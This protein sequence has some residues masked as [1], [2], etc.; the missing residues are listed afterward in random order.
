MPGTRLTQGIAALAILF[1]AMAVA[2]DGEIPLFIGISL[3]WVIA[4]RSI[5]FDR[6]CRTVTGSLGVERSLDRHLI[7]EMN[8]TR[9]ATTVTLAVPPRVAVAVREILPP[10][11]FLHQGTLDAE[12]TGTEVQVPLEIPLTYEIMAKVHG[13]LKFP[14]ISLRI[15]DRFF[16]REIL[17]TA[18]GFGG[19]EILVQPRPDFETSRRQSEF[20]TREIEKSAFITGLGIRGFREYSAGDDLRQIDWKLS[21]KHEKLLIREYMGIMRQSPLLIID[22]PD[23][24]VPYDPRAFHRMVRGVAGSVEHSIRSNGHAAYLLISGVNILAM[25]SEEKHVLVALA[26]LRD[27]LHP[28]D[29]SSHAY[30]VLNRRDLRMRIRMLRAGGPA[31]IPP[32]I[33]AFRRALLLRYESHLKDSSL[34]LFYGQVAR[35]LS[36]FNREEIIIFSLLEGDVSHVRAITAIADTMKA[37]VSLRTGGQDSFRFLPRDGLLWERVEALP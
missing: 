17:L 6:A 25:V 27:N 24:G 37:R 33:E 15:A 32:E 8:T 35:A 5:L 26:N 13:T 7:L 21:A 10:G 11:I 34:P 18:P 31:E 36:L 1:V 9:I 14:G 23:R 19:T 4:A 12:V 30:R 29:R 28:V 16:A 20:G 2:T 3:L 22:L